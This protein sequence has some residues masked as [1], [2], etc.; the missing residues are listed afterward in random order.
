M[1]PVL[2]AVEAEFAREGTQFV[3][4]FTLAVAG[5]ETCELAQ[6]NARAASIAA[7]MCAAIVKPTGGTIFVGDYETRLQPPQAK[8]LVGFV[9]GGGFT[10][11]A[12]A[13]KCEVA[14]RAEVWSVEYA[15]ARVRAE[16]VLDELGDGGAYA[17]AVAL[18]LVADVALI[19]FDRPPGDIL[20]RVRGMAPGAAILFSSEPRL[21]ALALAPALSGAAP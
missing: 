2:R 3:A 4:P 11:D 14:F 1:N 18:A 15:A 13:F 19:V 12:H 6:P 21:E 16:R 8:R 20:R 10:G 9:D 7:R 17:R 5:A